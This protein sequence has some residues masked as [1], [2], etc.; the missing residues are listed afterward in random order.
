GPISGGAEPPRLND[1]HFQIMAAVR[2]G[3]DSP[4]G[5]G[6]PSFSQAERPPPERRADAT[7]P[8]PSPPTRAGGGGRRERPRGGGRGGGEAERTRPER[9]GG[10]GQEPGGRHP[11]R[12][13]TPSA[14]L[15]RGARAGRGLLQTRP[16]PRPPVTTVDPGRT[17]GVLA[18]PVCHGGARFQ[19]ARSQA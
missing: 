9:A 11:Q 14:R 5:G 15:G 8:R 10:A 18:S 3:F 6:D 1:L 19:P 13:R 17:G 16:R 4:S 12:P 2:P 7:L